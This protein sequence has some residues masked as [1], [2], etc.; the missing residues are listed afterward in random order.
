M[1]ANDVSPS[2]VSAFLDVSVFGSY[3]QGD[4]VF[5]CTLPSTCIGDLYFQRANLD[6]SKT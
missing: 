5:N 3:S 1:G 4:H 2:V 6:F